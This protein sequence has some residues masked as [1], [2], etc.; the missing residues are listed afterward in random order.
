MVG[1]LPTLLCLPEH[2]PPPA[3]GCRLAI[4][5]QPMPWACLLIFGQSIND[6]RCPLDTRHFASQSASWGLRMPLLSLHQGLGKGG[7]DHPGLFTANPRAQIK[8]PTPRGPRAPVRA[9]LSGPLVRLASFPDHPASRAVQEK[10]KTPA[11]P[12]WP[13]GELQEPRGDQARA[14]VSLGLPAR[15]QGRYPPAVPAARAQA[16][17]SPR[18]GRAWAPPPSSRPRRL[19]RCAR[20]EAQSARRSP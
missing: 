6:Q 12:S 8:P 4:S 17:H 19:H 13:S 3:P 11:A 9:A 20:G 2:S 1:R 18:H 10:D 5:P 16:A 14:A 7:S 15:P